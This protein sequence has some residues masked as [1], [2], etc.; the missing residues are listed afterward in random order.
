[1]SRL[2]SLSEGGGWKR[3]KEGGKEEWK[4]GGSKGGRER[5]REGGRF[6]T[7]LL[8]FSS[9]SESKNV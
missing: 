7:N 4:G 3:E 6:I 2:S 8:N 9:S 1:M 5:E